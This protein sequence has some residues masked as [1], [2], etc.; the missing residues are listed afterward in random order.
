MGKIEGLEKDQQLTEQFST[1]Q[2]QC[3]SQLLNYSELNTKIEYLRNTLTDLTHN[4]DNTDLILIELENESHKD[5]HTS[6]TALS[7][8]Y[9]VS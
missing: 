8:T 2:I 5:R 3:S 7:K 4:L 6:E 1:F 9:H